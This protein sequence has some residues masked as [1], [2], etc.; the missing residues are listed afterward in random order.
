MGR[1]MRKVNGNGNKYKKE[2]KDFSE[3]VKSDYNKIMMLPG[4]A[5]RNGAFFK[6][7]EYEKDKYMIPLDFDS[8]TMCI[9]VTGGLANT[10]NVVYDLYEGKN[11]NVEY[12]KKTYKY[13]SETKKLELKGKSVVSKLMDY[14]KI[15]NILV[16][17]YNININKNKAEDLVKLACRSEYIKV[18]KSLEEC[19][20]K[21][22]MNKEEYLKRLGNISKSNDGDKELLTA[23][24]IRITD[25]YNE[26]WSYDEIYNYFNTEKRPVFRAIKEQSD[27]VT[28]KEKFEELILRCY[29]EGMTVRE[30]NK[31]FKLIK[32]R[33]YTV[34]YLNGEF[35]T[36]AKELRK[37]GNYLSVSEK[38]ALY[39]YR[40]GVPLHELVHAV[41]D[42][43]GRERGKE[44][45]WRS[46]TR[47]LI[48][49][50]E[51]AG[52]M[53]GKDLGDFY[54]NAEDSKPYVFGNSEEGTWW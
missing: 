22:N 2:L 30:L 41:Q 54:K 17:N 24:Q 39:L 50:R 34:E 52:N 38:K 40:R 49:I 11:G 1:P 6:D 13:N 42:A 15:K 29:A 28:N 48:G 27:R 4:L 44:T 16:E 23:Y 25:K 9:R 46:Y 53:K 18:D 10:P 7:C 20:S 19:A 14:D 12:D 3:L 43:L 45:Y 21:F 33:G 51:G 32:V 8:N 37:K 36:K 47:F 26:G 31:Y 35:L 5:I